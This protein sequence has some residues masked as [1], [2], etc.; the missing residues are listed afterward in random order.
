LKGKAHPDHDAIVHQ[1]IHQKGNGQLETPV[2][3]EPLTSQAEYLNKVQQILKHI[4]LGDVYEMN[5]CQEFLAKNVRIPAPVDFYNTVNQITNAPF[6]CYLQFDEF[7]L[8]CGSPERFIEKRDQKL[9]A[10]PIKGT[11]PRGKTPEADEA[12]KIKLR[13]DPKEQS[14]N[15]MIVDLMRNDLSKI[16]TKNS[17][18]VPEL[19]GIYSFE[20]VHQMI[21]T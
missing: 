18:H 20:T 14:E 17:V 12:L 8:F 10:Q 16:A 2:E 9:S 7:N 1:F 4:Q 3:F 13:N 11:A 6:S 19:F 5:F 15:V 21:S